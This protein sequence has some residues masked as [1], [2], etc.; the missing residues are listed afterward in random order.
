MK[1]HF[2]SLQLHSEKGY[3]NQFELI[4]SSFMDNNNFDYQLKLRVQLDGK[5]QTEGFGFEVLL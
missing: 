3:P 4:R 2:E 5:I 1:S